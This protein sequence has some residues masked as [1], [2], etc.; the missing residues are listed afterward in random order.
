[1]RKINLIKDLDYNYKYK[2][3]N[4]QNNKLL[5][6]GDNRLNE[7]IKLSKEVYTAN[8]IVTITP[9]LESIATD[10]TNNFINTFESRGGLTTEQINFA[11]ETSKIILGELIE[12]IITVI[13]APCGFG[14]SSITSEI[15]QKIIS[16]HI[17][18]K[19]TDGIII[20]TDR[21]ESLRNTVEYLNQINLD[22]YAYVLEGWNQEICI[23]KKIKQSDAK[24]CTPNN[25]N[26]F[27]KCKISK[28]QKEQEKYPILLITNARL[29]ECADS[30]IKYKDWENGTRTILLIDERPDV[31]DV[32][33]V[34]KELLN[35]ISTTLS[36]LSYDTT[37]DK[38]NLEN[39]FKEISDT[40]NTE[41]QRL[42]G[43]E[44]KRFIV[45]NINNDMICKNDLE[46]MTFMG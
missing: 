3:L 30:I 41:M 40:I 4:Q 15:L 22:G 37:E 25:C 44:H 27:S 17:N 39:K 28:Q 16:L 36:K 19:S 45:S 1:M 31:L 7:I 35:K 13:P 6:D 12:N 34:S 2:I 46:F 43:S 11:N 32:V 24:V 14:K 18:K 38:T 9:E 29:R 26:F 23:N 21:L 8:E 33:K 5:L 20:I 42:R 10:I